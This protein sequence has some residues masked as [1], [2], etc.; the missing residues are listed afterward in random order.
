M[1]DQAPAPRAASQRVPFA[2][3]V[4]LLVLTLVF[5]TRLI[6][7]FTEADGHPASRATPPDGGAAG[8]AP[9]S[10]EIAYYTCSMHT[11]VHAHAPGNCPV[12]SMPLHA[13]TV[14]DAQTG[15]VQIDDARRGAI[16]IAT[17]R[18]T[19]APLTID[20][21]AVGKLAYDESALHD[22]VLKVGGYISELRVTAT[23]QAVRQGD[24]LFQL[25]SPEIFAAE[26][27][28]I[29][30]RHSR[31]AIGKG[32]ELVRAA[33]T[34]LALLGVSAAQIEQNARATTP[35]EQLTVRAP[36]SG[37]VIEKTIVDGAAVK[38]G[39]R[40][41]RIAGLDRV[42]VEADVFEP[43]LARIARGQAASIT[44]G[45]L[46]GK[47]FDGKVSFVYPYLD[48]S[49][50]TGRVRIELA[51]RER[52]LRPDMYA[53]VTFHL[54]L[55]ARLQIP[56]SAIL[57]TGA[58]KIVLVDLGGGR[59]APRDVQL[60]ALGRDRAEVISGLADGDAVVTAGNFLIAAESRIRSSGTFWTEAP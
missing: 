46:P 9:A 28:A 35:I 5:H 29:L 56:T 47:T 54:A 6:A 51:N 3:G 16:G 26:Q 11:S 39:D 52:E 43:E 45:G 37:Y 13:V 17:E 30:A 55:G 59:I 14:A 42:W 53:D 4:V 8:S 34:R 60:G 27:D 40:V 22:V 20:V 23:G 38:A 10:A 48:P 49:T 36:A 33:D 58:R 32:D 50:R 2:I 1:T 15:V 21:H 7:W 25:Y 41:F 57:Y 24:P 44:L 19:T 18:A 12:C 31:D